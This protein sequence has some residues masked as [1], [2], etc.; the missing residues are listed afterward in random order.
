[1]TKVSKVLALVILTGF[2]SLLPQ[3]QTAELS[4]PQLYEQVVV[5]T[6][7]I[8]V[9]NHDHE[10]F[11]GAAFLVGN[12]SRAITAWHLV[13]DAAEIE[14]SYSD[15]SSARNLKV[16]AHHPVHDLALLQVTPTERTP[17]PLNLETPRIASRVYAIGSPRGYVFSI[18]DGLLSQVQTI[19]GFPQFQLTCPFSPGNSGG[20]VVDASGRVIGLSAWSKL[21]AQN[22]NFAIPATFIASLCATVDAD[23][24][25]LPHLAHLDPEPPAH[26]D[27]AAL[28]LLNPEPPAT[29]SS[30]T[31]ELLH[32]HLRAL[33]GQQVRITV[34][35]DDHTRLFTWRV[36]EISATNRSPEPQVASA[37]PA[38]PQLTSD[39]ST[40]D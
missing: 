29:P 19:D 17:L 4:P 24:Q 5:S 1:M 9:R 2:S 37:I 14:G 12:S 36:P 31:L 28:S 32:Q 6:L 35:T 15:G 23:P 11:V 40:S 26:P 38:T 25:P 34:A 7:A 22:V 18:S 30:D 27:A 10:R 3:A 21:G 20:P 39:P 33:A 13:R 8:R 16:L